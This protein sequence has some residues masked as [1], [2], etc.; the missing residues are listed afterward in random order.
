MPELTVCRVNNSFA[1]PSQINHF[2]L[3]SSKT[4]GLISV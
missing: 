3:L 4:L 2:A 1:T